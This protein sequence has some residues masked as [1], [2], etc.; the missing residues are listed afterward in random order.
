MSMNVTDRPLPLLTPA[1][2]LALAL[3]VAVVALLF[4]PTFAL[5]LQR[6]Q[7]DPN[8]SHGYLVGPISLLMAG[9]A[10]YRVGRPQQSEM[11]LGLIYLACGLIV[12]FAALIASWP[13][14]DFVALALVLRGT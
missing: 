1:A 6:W 5:L 14:L 9:I 7:I 8:Y 12:H 2:M 4:A 13:L 3:L 11:A 10:I